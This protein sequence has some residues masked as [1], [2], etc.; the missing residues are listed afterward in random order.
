MIT[1]GYGHKDIKNIETGGFGMKLIKN[2]IITQIGDKYILI[3]SLNGLIDSIDH[4][5]LDIIAKWH[6]CDEIVPVGNPEEVLF[7]EL[8]S[9]GYLCSS[10]REEREKKE[11]IIC[12]LREKH[13]KIKANNTHMTFVMTYDC[14]FR[15]PYCFE[16]STSGGSDDSQSLNSVSRKTIMDRVLIDAAFALVGDSLKTI[17]LFGGEPLLP[18][19]MPALEYI[20]SRAPDKVYN[21]TTNGYYLDEFLDLLSKIKISYIMITLDGDEETHDSRRFL[22]NGRPTF[23]RILTNIEK[24]LEKNIPIRIRMNLDDGNFNECMDLRTK[25]ME[26]FKM[27]ENLLSFE[28][29]PMMGMLSTNRNNMLINLYKSDIEYSSKKRIQMN[30]MLS[31]FSPILNVLTTG[32]KLRPIYSFCSAHDSGFIVDPYG[33]IYP[34]LVSVGKKPL[35]IGKYYPDVEYFENSIRDRSIEKI[36]KCRECR[37]SLLCGGGCPVSLNNYSDL[38]KPEC[39]SITNQIHNILPMLYAAKKE[40]DLNKAERYANGK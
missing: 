25:L 27:Y 33:Y 19:N 39:F 17:G 4:S 1:V 31:R 12:A 20:I 15:C 37:Y 8:K 24:C 11:E 5:T 35:A 9:R 38:Y 6:E 21:I 14:N 28:I 18:K 2:L 16:N 40:C 10:H 26:Q 29:S 34:C 32:A 22:V 13:A 7:S 36:P 30:Q 23:K 3:N